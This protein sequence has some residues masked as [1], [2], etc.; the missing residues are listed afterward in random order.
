MNE[1]NAESNRTPLSRGVM[2][3]TG[4][5]AKKLRDMMV[6]R[7]LFPDEAYVVLDSLFGHEH[8]KPL[9]DVLG[10]QIDGYPNEFLVVSWMLVRDEVVKWIDANKP[11]HWARPMFLPPEERA[12]RGI[13]YCGEKLD[14]ATGGT[15]DRT[16]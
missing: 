5:V 7:G 12:A 15:H 11:K 13:S 6:E 1:I 8:L 4:T 2:D 3:Q 9:V 16:R 14:G 10:K